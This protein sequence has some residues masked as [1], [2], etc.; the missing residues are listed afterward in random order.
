MRLLFPLSGDDVFISYSRKDGSLYTAGLADK[1]TEKKLSCFIDRLG[2]EPGRE[3]PASL[4]KKIK[5][6]SVF[7]LVGTERSFP[8]RICW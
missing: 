2:S 1:L 5:T 3:L 8:L 7:V 4:K 6:C